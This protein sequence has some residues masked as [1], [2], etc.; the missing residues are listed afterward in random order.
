MKDD[1]ILDMII[2]LCDDVA[3]ARSFDDKELFN[4]TA[5]KNVPEKLSK[6]AESFGLM[7]VKVESRDLYNTRLIEELTAKNAELEEAKQRLQTRNSRLIGIVKEKYSSERLVGQCST[8]QAVIKIADNIA[9]RP[10]NTMLLGETGTGKEVFAKY[11]HFN[12][13]RCEGPFVPVN[14]TAIPEALFESEMFG[15]EKG[16]ATGVN[17]RKGLFEEANGGTLFLD[18]LADMSLPNQ[19]KLLRALE[20]QEIYRVGSSKPI[21][22]NV[23]VISATNVNIAKAMQEGKFRQDLYYR[24]AVAEIR[25]P[26]LHE[27]GEDIILLA[28]KF[29]DRYCKQA[30]RPNLYLSEAVKE[31]FLKYSWPGNVRELNNEMER[32]SVLCFSELVEFS[33]LSQRIQEFFQY[34]SNTG[35][36]DEEEKEPKENA[37]PTHFTEHNMQKESYS[38]EQEEISYNLLEN[39]EKLVIKTLKHCDGNRT[40][41]A[42]LL[43]ITREGLRKKLIR[44]GLDK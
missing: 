18:E 5:D 44:M 23:K 9:K 17:H 33:D 27:R 26:P 12:S 25:I 43:G 41:A 32:L 1:R 34:S 36:Q 15:I 14:C 4:L 6:L 22:I 3:W 8:M 39:E 2:S 19:A 24:L 35:Y 7:L 42:A 21:P 13:P 29:L 40:K 38:F 11:I 31:A 20:E 10:I 30:V 16:V 28:Q 37:I